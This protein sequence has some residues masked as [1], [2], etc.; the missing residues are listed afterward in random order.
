MPEKFENGTKFDGK[1][2]L[3]IFDAEEMYLNRTNRSVSSQKRRKM[4]CFQ[5]FHVLRRCRFQNVPVKVPF[6]EFTVFEICRQ[7]MYRFRV[8]GRPIHHIFHRFQNVPASCE[9]GLRFAVQ[10]FLTT[11]YSRL[12]TLVK[13]NF[14]QL[15]L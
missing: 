3:Q 11:L 7:N 10:Y 9:C 5:H 12:A 2:S 15:L 6:S 4:L 13:S 14:I 8:D 1:N